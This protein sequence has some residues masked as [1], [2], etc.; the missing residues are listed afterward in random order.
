[1]DA[2]KKVNNP[3]LSVV[4]PTLN[5][6]EAMAACLASLASQRDLAMEVVVSDGGSG[7]GTLE[8]I[9]SSGCDFSCAVTVVAG[10]RGRGRQLNTGANAARG[11]KLLFLHA[12]S[13][14]PD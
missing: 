14:F 5:D 6:R 9:R 3:E 2:S 11:E 4:I 12:D 13:L 7:D 1:M 8:L 10:E